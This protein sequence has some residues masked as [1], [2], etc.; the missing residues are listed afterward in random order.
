M[1]FFLK[2][3]NLG[4]C[5]VDLLH[6]GRGIFATLLEQSGFKQRYLRHCSTPVEQ[7]IEYLCLGGVAPKVNQTEM[8]M[9]ERRD[10]AAI[11]YILQYRITAA[12]M[13]VY[14]GRACGV[15]K[16]CFQSHVHRN[17][18]KQTLSRVHHNY[19]KTCIMLSPISKMPMQT[20]VTRPP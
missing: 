12:V 5:S 6:Q 20:L 18:V 2:I 3:N 1:Y 11:E 9:K 10:H 4:L 7:L 13:Y 14:I 15:Y 16:K 17:Y 19:V 8:M